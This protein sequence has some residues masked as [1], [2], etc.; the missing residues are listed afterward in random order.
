M[1]GSRPGGV[2]VWTQNA[3]GTAE[4]EKSLAHSIHDRLEFSH[5]DYAQNERGA[6]LMSDAVLRTWRNAGAGKGVSLGTDFPVAVSD[7]WFPGPLSH[8][9]PT[10]SNCRTDQALN[11][12][13]QAP[14][15]GLPDCSGAGESPWDD[16]GVNPGPS[17]DDFERAGIPIPEN[18][19]AAGYTGLEEDLGIHLQA[20][21][22]G[23]VLLTICSCEQWADQA[24][25]IK[26]RTDAAQ[27]NEY[28]GYDWGAQCT[29]LGSGDWSCPDPRDTSRK[30]PPIAD[31]K[32][33]RMR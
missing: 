21:R 6:R 1:E 7:K 13:P 23:D 33:R 16:I 20:V 22:L 10:V 3:V 11:G 27:G 18:Y 14:V 17:T 5:R 4:P 32:Y 25:N 19:G 26:T 2:T 8:P 29:R 30:L 15:V 24:R 31:L 28:L 9:F 12:N